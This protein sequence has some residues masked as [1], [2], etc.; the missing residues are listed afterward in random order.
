MYVIVVGV[1]FTS[2]SVSAPTFLT[3]N[4]YGF[5]FPLKIC[6]RRRLFFNVFLLYIHSITYV[7]AY[8]IIFRIALGDRI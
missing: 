8:N 7:I 3:R 6:K 1:K 4:C 2:V 5:F